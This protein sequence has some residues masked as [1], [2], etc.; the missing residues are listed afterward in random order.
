MQTHPLFCRVFYITYFVLFKL[1]SLLFFFPLALSVIKKAASASVSLA[2]THTHTHTW[3]ETVGLFTYL[4]LRCAFAPPIDI[5][6]VRV[7]LCV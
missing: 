1:F 5:V 6:R 3:A 7:C 2:H 4:L